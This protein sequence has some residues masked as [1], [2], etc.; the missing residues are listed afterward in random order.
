MKC[1]I[2]GGED[3]VQVGKV[4]AYRQVLIDSEGFDFGP[5]EP[6]PE[7]YS[8]LE[9]NPYLCNQCYTPFSHKENKK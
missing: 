4:I 8:P 6:D 5:I 2:C 3:I 9:Y 1:P 7:E